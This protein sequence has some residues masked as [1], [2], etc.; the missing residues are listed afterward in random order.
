ML[1]KAEKINIFSFK[2]PHMRTFH[3]TW[4]TFFIC[5]FGWFGIAPLM[6]IIRD[7]LHLTKSQIGNVIIA[8]VSM[9]VFARL[10]IG[11]LCDKFGPRLTYT[12][13]LLIGSLPV[14]CI[15]LSNSYESFLMFR[16]AI[17]FIGASFV[18]TQYHTSIMFAPSIVGTA[19]ATTAGWGNLGGGVTQMVMPMIFA[20][21]VF[22]GYSNALAWRYSMIVPGVALF[23]MGFIYYFFTQDTPEGNISD[24]KK[25]PTTKETESYKVGDVLKNYRVWILFLIYGAC[26]GMEITINN[27]AA[28]YYADNFQLGLKEAGIIAGLYGMMNIFARTLGGYASDKVS[29]KY[30]NQKRIVILGFLLLAES[31]GIMIFAKSTVLVV[32]ISAMMFFA[33]FVQMANG[34]T[35]SI[36]PFINKKAIGFVAGIVG[37]GG[38]AGAMLAGM[39]LKSE[40]LTYSQGLQIISIAVVVISFLTFFIQLPKDTITVS[41]AKEKVEFSSIAPELK[42]DKIKL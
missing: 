33:L 12:G 20:G 22:L 1:G 24:L 26:F 35:F 34:A 3:I 37:A 2:A 13:V 23:I 25:N 7:E 36:V 14:M 15:G 8:S 9:T 18:I 21:F 38:I 5:F 29:A 4:M 32:A 19:N 39:V 10:L 11:W 6:P 31:I 42:F 40:N 27:I 30:G 28:I 17:G 41:N 16:L